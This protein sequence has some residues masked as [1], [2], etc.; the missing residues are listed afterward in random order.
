MLFIENRFWLLSR[1]NR[2]TDPAGFLTF[3]KEDVAPSPV[4]NK[5]FEYVGR[6]RCL[7]AAVTD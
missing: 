1:C 4:A 2:P 7:E 5:S 3:W 6:F